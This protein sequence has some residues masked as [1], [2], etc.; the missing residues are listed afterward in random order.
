MAHVA[1]RRITFWRM[2]HF[3]TIPCTIIRKF[4]EMLPAIPCKLTK[5]TYHHRRS[6]Q[7]PRTLQRSAS[8]RNKCKHATRCCWNTCSVYIF[9]TAR[10]LHTSN[11]ILLLYPHVIYEFL[12]ELKIVSFV[13]IESEREEVE[14]VSDVRVRKWSPIW[15]G[16]KWSRSENDTHLSELQM[17]PSKK[18]IVCLTVLDA[19]EGRSMDS[20]YA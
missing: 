17:I 20:H 10:V 1:R 3:G 9:T 6:Q 16:S 8:T 7:N 12:K 11:T 18:L 15:T 4:Q 19:M 5:D 13:L 2:F 14:Y